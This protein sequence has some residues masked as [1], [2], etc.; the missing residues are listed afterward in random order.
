MVKRD[1]IKLT[2]KILN[3]LTKPVSI[4]ILVFIGVTAFVIVVTGYKILSIKPD[5]TWGLYNQTFLEN[6]LVEAHGMLFDILIIGI[7]ILFLNTLAEKRITNQRYLDEI[8]DFRGWQSDEAAHRIA[9]N[10]K[11]LK[12][13]QYKGYIDLSCCYL[14]SMDL[15]EAELMKS[16]LQEANLERAILLKANFQ[17]ANI[18]DA[19]L[20]EADLVRT[21]LG[22]ANLEGANLER[23]NLKEAN[24]RK[25]NLVRTNLVR[26]N[27]GKANLEG[28]NLEGANLKEANLRKANLVR[29]NLVRTNFVRAKLGKAN[30]EGANLEEADLL[31]VKGL[32]IE[33]LSVIKTLFGANLEY[34]L[35][36]QVKEKYPHLLEKPKKE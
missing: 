14:N 36:E 11:R 1:N 6:V 3:L 20:Q 4:S 31:A 18:R 19:F 13:N 12:R 22:K 24:L 7:L 17:E 23:A 9:G 2:Q 8:D 15:R 25:A 26:T 5:I 28:A 10:I 33:Q 16:N 21:N 27:L 34:E 30:L 32:T 29:A 35:K